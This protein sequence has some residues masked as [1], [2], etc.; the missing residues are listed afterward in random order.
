M[1]AGLGV[2][3]GS[4]EGGVGLENNAPHRRGVRQ[5]VGRGHRPVIIGWL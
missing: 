3:P 4:P 5:Q 2:L 1:R